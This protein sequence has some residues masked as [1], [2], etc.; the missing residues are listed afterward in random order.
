MQILRCHG[1]S[2]QFIQLI[3]E[4]VPTPSFSIL[5]NGSPYDKFASTRGLRQGDPMSPALF[6][7]VFDL[8]SRLLTRAENENCI[9]GVKIRRISLR[10]SYFMFVDDLTIYCRSIVE[11]AVEIGKCLDMFCS[12]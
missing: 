5:I 1:F 3:K 4:C 2:K 6:T 10:F 12:W 8:L 7:F 11:E 9:H